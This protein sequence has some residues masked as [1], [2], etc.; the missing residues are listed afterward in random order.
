MNSS[1]SFFAAEFEYPELWKAVTFL[2]GKATKPEFAVCLHRLSC[3]GEM[4]QYVG[5]GPK[6]VSLQKLQ[7]VGTL[8]KHRLSFVRT[9]YL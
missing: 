1:S 7:L 6:F 5:R 8:S 3:R 4:Q 2:R 9:S